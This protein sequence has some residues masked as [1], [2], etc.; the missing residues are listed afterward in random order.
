MLLNE[1]ERFGGVR[2]GGGNEVLGKEP[3]PLQIF[4]QEIRCGKRVT[5][6]LSCDS[7]IDGLEILQVFQH[8]STRSFS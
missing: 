2:I 8:N 4:P 1:C 5:N 6:R 3:S 7:H